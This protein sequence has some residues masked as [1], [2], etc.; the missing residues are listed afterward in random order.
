M[1]RKTLEFLD[2]LYQRIGRLAETEGVLLRRAKIY[3]ATLG[4]ITPPS[5]T[6][7]NLETLYWQM[8][9]FTEAEQLLPQ[10]L[11]IYESKLGADHPRPSRTYSTHWPTCIST[12]VGLPR[13]S[14]LP[15]Q[16]E[17]QK[18]NWEIAA[19]P[20]VAQILFNIG[21]LHRKKGEHVL[22]K[23]FLE[24]A[25]KIYEA[26]PGDEHPNVALIRKCLH[27]QK[28]KDDFFQADLENA[29]MNIVEKRRKALAGRR[30]SRS[31]EVVPRKAL[32][33]DP[34]GSI[35]NSPWNAGGHAP[36]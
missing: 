19:T 12:R 17:D 31:L 9:R 5:Q 6:L 27:E 30:T 20:E 14:F 21:L 35:R 2:V 1:S 33:P 24:R 28:A 11:K 8:E 22:A 10:C 25:L 4:P 26:Q 16:L 36:G 23:S 3:E 29:V 7:Y 15:T 13:P 18:G 32:F 34:A